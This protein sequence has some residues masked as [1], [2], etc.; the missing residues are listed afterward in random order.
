MSKADNIFFNS[1]SVIASMPGTC[2]KAHMTPG[3]SSVRSVF[4][5]VCDTK[6]QKMGVRC[7]KQRGEGNPGSKLY[8]VVSRVCAKNLIG[9][10]LVGFLIVRFLYKNDPTPTKFEDLSKVEAKSDQNATFIT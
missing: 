5:P 2:S 1:T 10:N 6:I 4:L 7:L 9:I 8:Q 3:I